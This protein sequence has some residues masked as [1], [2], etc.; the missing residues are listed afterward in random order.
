VARPVVQP[1]EEAPAQ[2][3]GVP[4]CQE[5]RVDLLRQVAEVVVPVEAA[6]Q[7]RGDDVA[8]PV[9][10]GAGQQAR[11]PDALLQEGLVPDA[12]DLDIAAGGEVDVAAVVRGDPGQ[13]GPVP[14]AQT[15]AGKAQAGDPAVGGGE[16]P[17]H[18]GAAIAGAGSG[19]GLTMV[20][21]HDVPSV[22]EPAAS[23]LVRCR[24]SDAD[25]ACAVGSCAP[26][27]Q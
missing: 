4:G 19:S 14:G 22:I 17:Q 24:G 26:D 5:C 10:V 23:L 15:S 3:G 25:P 6:G 11:R 12:A 9:V 7:G 18:A 13:R 20:G 27:R 2:P 16:R 21:G 8:D 1:E